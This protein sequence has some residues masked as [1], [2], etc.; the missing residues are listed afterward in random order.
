MQVAGPTNMFLIELISF[1]S[2]EHVTNCYVSPAYF[3]LEQPC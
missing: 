2:I 3:K 1:F